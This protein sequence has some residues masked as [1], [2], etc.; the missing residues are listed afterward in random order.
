MNLFKNYKALIIS[1]VAV[2]LFNI[3]AFCVLTVVQ[4]PYYDEAPNEI[5]SIYDLYVSEECEKVLYWSSKGMVLDEE[6]IPRIED[7]LKSASA[8]KLDKTNTFKRLLLLKKKSFVLMVSNKVYEDRE[9]AATKLVASNMM[10]YLQDD[11]VYIVCKE[12]VEFEFS[13][14][15]EK[16]AIYETKNAELVE[17]LSEYQT[18][19]GYHQLVP[20]WR[21]ELSGAGKTFI[22]NV[23]ILFFVVEF[24]VVLFIVNKISEKK[25]P[26]VK[27]KKKTANSKKKTKRT[28][29]I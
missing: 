27:D 23:Y 1:I 20:E 17:Y 24:V 25:S 18:D 22:G 16:I 15:Y 5:A 10:F 26:M 11:T 8:K 9:V 7:A 13:K 14:K 28:H 29:K 2:L 3:I 6:E 19:E 21:E 12:F 4:A